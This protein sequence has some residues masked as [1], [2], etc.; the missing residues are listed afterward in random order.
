MKETKVKTMKKKKELVSSGNPV[1]M[2]NTEVQARDEEEI[3]KKAHEIYN[4]RIEL[5]INGSAEEDW[6][7][8]ERCLDNKF[9]SNN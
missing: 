7:D 1:S 5:G 6:H 2:N 3:R 8:A 9:D 4:Y